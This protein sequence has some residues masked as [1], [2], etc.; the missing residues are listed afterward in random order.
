M[1]KSK[2]LE[3]SIQTRLTTNRYLVTS[4][5][6]YDITAICRVELFE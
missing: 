1:E 5:R 3:K 4:L 2:G 6:L